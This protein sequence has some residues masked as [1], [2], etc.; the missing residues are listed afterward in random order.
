MQA[1]WFG[2]IAVLWAGFFLLEGFDFGVGMLLPLVARDEASKHIALRSIGPV[3]DGNEVWLIVAG[4]AT[5]AAFPD[6]YATVFSGFYLAF[7]LLLVGLILRGIGIEY[8]ERAATPAGRAWCDRAIVVGSTLPALLIGVAFA[9]FLRGVD[10]NAAHD[11]TGGFFALLSP[12]ALLGGL[13]TLSLFTL[14]G[15]TFLSLRTSGIVA[16]R[17]RSVDAVMGPSTVVFTA[18]F[19]AWTARLRGGWVSV[20]LA[21]VILVALLV[22]N[23]TA[24]RGREGLAFL[25][26][27]VVTALLPVW[28]FAALWPD[29][30]P[31]KNN[32]AFSLTVH[33]ASSSPYTLKVMTVVALVFTPIVI[34]YQ[35]WT[36]WIF[37]ARVTGDIASG[38]GYDK[39]DR[40]LAAAKDSARRTL[41]THGEVTAGQDPPAGPT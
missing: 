26:T 28:T 5:F 32:S 41:G 3:W 27:S 2:T 22:A 40:T 12:Y 25:S 35:A 20:A 13:V 21:V 14:H 38:G 37:R 39:L 17:A 11:M 23:A 36:Y 33:N 10:M 29:V 15:A 6:W 1:F 30:L 16:D 18:V 9:D 31:A 34:V 7:A 19:V 8:R 24:V 4:G